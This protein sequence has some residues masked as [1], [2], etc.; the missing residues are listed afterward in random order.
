[1]GTRHH[2][3][4]RDGAPVVPR[5]CETRGLRIGGDVRTARLHAGSPARG[6]CVIVSMRSGSSAGGCRA[7]RT[8]VLVP[9]AAR[10]AATDAMLART[11]ARPARHARAMWSIPSRRLGP[12]RVPPSVSSAFEVSIDGVRRIA[13]AARSRTPNRRL[14]QTPVVGLA[15]AHGFPR[16]GTA[17][18]IVET[19]F[20]ALER[21]ARRW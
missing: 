2:Q 1:M 13:G 7:I 20:T 14:H 19:W 6:P 17:G 5:S 11:I 16:G 9:G 10:H 18:W 12:R 3:Q 15:P 8:Q 21:L 4:S